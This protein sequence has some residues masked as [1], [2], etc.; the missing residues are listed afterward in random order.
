MASQKFDLLL[1]VGRSNEYNMM[2]CT[3][4]LLPTY[5]VGRDP[6]MASGVGG[7]RHRPYISTLHP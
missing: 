4:Y 5:V 3:G 6:V 7:G 2:S 1:L